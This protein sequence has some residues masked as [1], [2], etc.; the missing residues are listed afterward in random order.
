MDEVEL[1]LNILMAGCFIVLF[2]GEISRL[3]IILWR[4][5]H[6]PSLRWV[7]DMLTRGRGK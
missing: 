3:L 4:K 7:N 1:H 2:S 5:V 6:E